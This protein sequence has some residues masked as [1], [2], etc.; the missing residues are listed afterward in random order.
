[1]Y[2]GGRSSDSGFI[3]MITKADDEN[4]NY[5]TVNYREAKIKTIKQL[6]P[7][8]NIVLLG[9]WGLYCFLWIFPIFYSGKFS[10]NL[11]MGI[12]WITAVIIINFF[13]ARIMAGFLLLSEILGK[14]LLEYHACE[15]KVISLITKGLW[16]SLENLKKL[17]RISLHC[18][19]INQG[20]GAAAPLI[21]GILYTV[22]N[23]A[24]KI[25]LPIVVLLFILSVCL[26]IAAPFLLQLFF[27]TAE[28]SEEKLKEALE[29]AKEYYK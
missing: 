16:P 1:M 23:L 17:P 4:K 12:A 19:S 13:S 8:Y 10:L 27:A 29:V 15:H 7:K 26:T 25:N 24:P 22:L 5:K 20:M 6:Q 9:V 18:G 11:W 28:P 14:N 2:I 3:I 21:W